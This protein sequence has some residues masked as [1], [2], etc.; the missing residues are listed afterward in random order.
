MAFTKRG[1]IPKDQ[2]LG[3]NSD[4][5]SSAYIRRKKATTNIK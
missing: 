3:Q 5:S 1:N 2:Q 4:N